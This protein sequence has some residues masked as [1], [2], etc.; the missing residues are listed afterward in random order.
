MSKPLFF[1]LA[2]CLSL[3]GC[4]SFSSS[5]TWAKVTQVRPDANASAGGDAS[6]TYAEKLH[7]V[8][9]AASVEHKLVTYQYHYRTPLRED[10]VETHTA[11]IYRDDRDPAN[12]WWLMEDR[13]AEPVWVSGEDPKD[14]I[15]FYL[16]HEDVNL[17]NEKDFPAKE[18]NLK[19]TDA[20]ARSSTGFARGGAS[21]SGAPRSGPAPKYYKITGYLP[22]STAPTSS[23]AA[24]FRSV[25]GTDYDPSSPVDRRKMEILRSDASWHRPSPAP[26]TN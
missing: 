9:K 22:A 6:G 24:L 17:V 11:V 19:P 13:L 15:T 4:G 1:A 16:H 20:M 26:K 23:D 10:A 21:H 5:P 2:G 18:E 14:Q 7:G 3:S 8:L 12:P 25:H